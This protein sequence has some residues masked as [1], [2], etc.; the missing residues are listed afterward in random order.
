MPDIFLYAGEANPND[1]RLRNPLEAGASTATA[2]IAWTEEDDATAITAALANSITLAWTEAD[3]TASITGVVSQ[4]V[5]LAWTED[6]DVA[7]I[8]ATV[9]AASADAAVN[10]T[11]E[12]DTTLIVG[13]VEPQRPIYGSPNRKAAIERDDEEVVA[14]LAVFLSTI[15]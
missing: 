12:D 9:A 5:T 7:A 15:T 2:T 1:V 6:N 14:A 13:A 4:A 8:S 11:E 3:D 10:W